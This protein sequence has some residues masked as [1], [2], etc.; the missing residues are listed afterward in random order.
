MKQIE[1]V[2]PLLGSAVVRYYNHSWLQWQGNEWSLAKASL[3]HIKVVA[4]H[5]YRETLVWLPIAE[6]KLVKQAV[7]LDLDADEVYFIGTAENGKTPVLKFKLD[8]GLSEIG[9]VW[10]PESLLLG[11]LVSRD[12]VWTIES[13]VAPWH[14]GVRKGLPVSQLAKGVFSQPERF[15]AAQGIT[16][17]TPEPISPSQLLSLY[18]K[19]WW[20]L[21]FAAWS[22]LW[23]KSSQRSTF[24]LAKLQGMVIP[25]ALMFTLYL[26]GSRYWVDLQR[27]HLA[28]DAQTQQQVVGD[29]LA[30]RNQAR[31]IESQ[32]TSFSTELDSVEQYWS[33]WP[34][35][36]AVFASG[37]SVDGV[38]VNQEQVLLRVKG[39]SATAILDTLL[40]L[41]EVKEA[42]FDGSVR[43]IRG[44]ES[45]NVLVIFAPEQLQNAEG[46]SDAG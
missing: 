44:E 28:T 1:A 33:L 39:Q 6:R 40:S 8:A 38:R 27:S 12:G 19:Q 30:L 4:R 2:G 46:Q 18:Q 43:R 25:I 31:D 13:S 24:N 11:G 42:R 45:V 22:G 5:H 21:P 23:R 37:A 35:L 32:I 3:H 17:V 10:L 29:A 26:V 15:C 34:T 36:A 14:L 20:R 7:E 41:P 9:G 16:E